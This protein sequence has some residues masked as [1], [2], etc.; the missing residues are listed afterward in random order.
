MAYVC[1]LMYIHCPQ[2]WW[3]VSLDILEVG[4]RTISNS[5]NIRFG[6]EYFV[7][8]LMELYEVEKERILIIVGLIV[9]TFV[10]KVINNI[11]RR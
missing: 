5:I 1:A 11:V 2:F 7:L 10:F 6:I 3:G 4:S 9:M 8:R